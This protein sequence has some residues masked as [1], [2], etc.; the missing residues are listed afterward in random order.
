MN[1]PPVAVGI[2]QLFKCD[3]PAVFLL[4]RY[5]N[6]WRWLN[7]REDSPWY[8]T[9]RIFRQERSGEWGPVIARVATALAAMAARPSPAPE[10]RGAA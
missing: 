3:S 10:C 5:D 4:D 6:C 7:G 2:P 1:P 8:P 9:L